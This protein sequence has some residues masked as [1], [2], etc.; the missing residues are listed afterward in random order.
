MMNAEEI[1]Q[2]TRHDLYV[3]LL[4]HIVL[5]NGGLISLD[6]KFAQ[7]ANNSDLML[8]IGSDAI[9]TTPIDKFPGA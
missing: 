6:P 3:R 2:N 5:Q 4:R 7:E 9:R 1:K 8:E